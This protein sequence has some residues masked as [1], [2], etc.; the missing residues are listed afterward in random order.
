MLPSLGRIVY[1]GSFSSGEG[2]RRLYRNGFLVGGGF[3]AFPC[4]S[5]ATQTTG[6]IISRVET[7]N[8][9]GLN[10]F[11][12]RDLEIPKRITPPS[13]LSFLSL[14]HIQ[15][16]PRC[17]LCCDCRGLAGDTH[18][19]PRLRASQRGAAA[20]LQRGFPN[21][22]Y[23]LTAVP[24]TSKW[25]PSSNDATPMKARDGKFLLKYVRYT[26]LNLA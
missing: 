15:Q 7:I 19:T 11:P 23:C 16:P 4:F 13:D 10:S 24:W 25:P 22:S 9:A 6:T 1:E 8:K 14:R 5:A 26:A 20:G 2:Q 12:N 3:W 18:A 17:Y 21:F